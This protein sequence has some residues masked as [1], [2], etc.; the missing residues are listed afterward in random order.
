MWGGLTVGALLI[1]R[2]LG[3]G[4]VMTALVTE[5]LIARAPRPLAGALRASNAPIIKFFPYFGAFG[6]LSA[7][8]RR[9][10]WEN[11][12]FKA[13]NAPESHFAQFT[14]LCRK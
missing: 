6:R 1:A 9:I 11:G 12:A 10:L 7:P 3:F 14:S 13:S 2:R 8:I 5:F 4:K